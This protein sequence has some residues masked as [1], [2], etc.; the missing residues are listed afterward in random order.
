MHLTGTHKFNASTDKIWSKLMDVNTLER[1]TPGVSK[2]E[3]IGTDQYKA[4]AEVK[5]GPVSGSFSGN[6]NVLDKQEPRSFVLN[7]KQNSKIGN[8]AADVKIEL[9]PLSEHE[10]QLSCDG[11]ANMAGLLARTGQRVM[12]G[13]ANTLSKQFFKALEEELANS[14]SQEV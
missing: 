11:K 4:I 3:E 14:T 2:L 13:V 7:I 6:L 9:Q 10:T 8:V 1:I 5:M 12:S